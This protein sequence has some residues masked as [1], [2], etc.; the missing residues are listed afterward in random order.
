MPAH[1]KPPAIA[2]LARRDPPVVLGLGQLGA[3]GFFSYSRAG[4]DES[5]QTLCFQGW[6]SGFELSI[7]CRFLEGSNTAG[8]L[9]VARFGLQG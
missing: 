1:Q 9:S 5:S 6:A 2:Y 3:C 7:A 8:V 4:Q